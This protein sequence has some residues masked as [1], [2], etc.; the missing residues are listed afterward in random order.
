MASE[1]ARESH[2]PVPTTEADG[3]T[4]PAPGSNVT[5]QQWQSMQQLLRTVYEYRTSDGYDPSKVFHRKVNKRVLPTYYEFIQEP[6]ALSTI[7]SKLQAKEY[8]EF[9][10]FV[11][12]FALIPHNAFV[13]NRSDSGAYKDAVEIKTLLE[14]ELQKLVDSKVASADEAKLPYL[15]E[16]PE[17]ED[18]LAEERADEE[19]EEDDEDDDDDD[20]GDESDDSKKQPKRGPGRPKGTTG[21]PKRTSSQREEARLAELEARKKRG[22]PPRVDTPTEARIK[23]ILK[24]LRRHKDNAGHLKIRH[25]D[26]LPDKAVMPDYFAEIKFPIAVDVLKVCTRQRTTFSSVNKRTEKTE[27]QEISLCRAAHERY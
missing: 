1:A 22:R 7:K 17:Q 27:T 20:E 6:I 11:R 12:D 4:E 19:A 15:G 14:S 8:K 13:F 26:R 3:P 24:S 21:I 16:I 25:F 9:K 23:N 10:D 5:A 18:E 2:T